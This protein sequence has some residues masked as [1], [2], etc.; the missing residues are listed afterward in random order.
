M[1][2]RDI[3]EAE[4]ILLGVSDVQPTRARIRQRASAVSVAVDDEFGDLQE[5]EE[6][7]IEFDKA[8]PSEFGTHTVGVVQRHDRGWGDF[9]KNIKVLKTSGAFTEADLDAVTVYVGNNYDETRLPSYHSATLIAS[10]IWRMKNGNAK[11]TA[12]KFATY[13]KRIPEI[14]PIDV[15]RYLRMSDLY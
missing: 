11:I 3:Q 9:M 2:S 7:E 13:M 10:L 5:A 8:A 6:E 14:N 1:T 12:T 4:E 15:L